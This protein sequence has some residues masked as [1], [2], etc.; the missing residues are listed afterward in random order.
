MNAGAVHVAE[1]HD[2]GQIHRY[3]H[4]ILDEAKTWTRN[5]QLRSR[6]RRHGKEHGNFKNNWGLCV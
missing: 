5:L 3:S 4:V 1:V 2:P 6:Q